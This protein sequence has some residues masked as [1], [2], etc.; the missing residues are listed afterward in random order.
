MTV[1]MTIDKSRHQSSNLRPTTDAVLQIQNQF[2]R[3]A[4]PANR[5]AG[6]ALGTSRLLKNKRINSFAPSLYKRFGL[7]NAPRY[8]MS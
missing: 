5:S 6:H 4:H 2:L 1:L 7:L 8:L 3:L